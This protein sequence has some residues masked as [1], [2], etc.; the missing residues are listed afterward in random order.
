MEIVVNILKSIP[1]IFLA[2]MI[3]NVMIVVHEWGHFLAAR[4]RGLK[5][6]KFQIWFG[7]PIWKKTINGVQY[8]L[9]C[10]PAGG[11]VL[12]PQMAPME[13]IEGRSEE[14]QPLPAI[15]PLDKIIVALAGPLF[16]FLLAVVFA[17]AVWWAGRPITEPPNPTKIGYIKPDKPVAQSGLRVGDIIRKIDGQPVHRWEGQVSSVRWGIV[18]SEGDEIT[19]TVERDGQLLDFKV[20]PVRGQAESAAPKNWM[21]RTFQW[22]FGRPPLREVGLASTSTTRVGRVLPNSP[23]ATAAIKEGDFIKAVDGRAMSHPMEVIDRVDAKKDQPLTLTVVRGDATIDVTVTPR[24]PDKPK[25][26][27][28]YEIGIGFGDRKRPVTYL[29]QTPAEQIRESLQAMKNLLAAITSRKSDISP[30]H[31]GGPVMIVRIYTNFLSLP[32]AWRWVLWFSV[33]LNVNLAV[34]NMLPFPVLDGGHITM[35][36]IEWV[37]RRPINVRVLE[38]VQTACVLLVL[39]FFIMVTLKD[40]GDLPRGGEIEFLPSEETRASGP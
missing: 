37:R 7:K 4:W 23:A 32:D 2:L 25:G 30:A 18:A 34:L 35:A 15:S 12:L 11:F 39:S 21:A 27:N 19:F 9:G 40:F 10:I 33:M 17:F 8:G 31:M 38:Y 24:I 13:A 16:S 6:E 26:E 22:V 3:L 14:T 29:R 5:I 28:N 36:L 1:V 20:K